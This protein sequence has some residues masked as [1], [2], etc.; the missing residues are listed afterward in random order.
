MHGRTD[1]IIVIFKSKAVGSAYKD[2][3]WRVSFNH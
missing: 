2:F 3:C 1:D